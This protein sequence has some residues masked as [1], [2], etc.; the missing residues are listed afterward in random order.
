MSVINAVPSQTAAVS[1]N[2]LPPAER[3][4]SSPAKIEWA[5]RQFESLLISQLL[6]SMHEPDSSGWLGAGE[7]QS[8]DSA[9]ELAEE[10]FAQALASGGGLGLAKLIMQGLSNQSDTAPD[11][12]LARTQPARLTSS[13]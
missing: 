9:M 6:K 5:A 8:A 7:D 12:V 10:Q 4:Q 11:A 13:R 2:S 1:E 3:P